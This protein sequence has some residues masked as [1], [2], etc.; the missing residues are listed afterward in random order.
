VTTCLYIASPS[1]SGSTLLTMLL[2]AHPAI[3]TIGE[4][5]GGQEELSSYG[6]SCGLLLLQCPFWNNLITSLEERGFTYDLSDLRTMP[7]FRTTHLWLADAILRRYSSGRL[8][9]AVRDYLFAIWPPWRKQLK[10]LLAYNETF[11]ELVIEMTGGSVFLDSSKDV[12]RIQYLTKIP[13]LDVRIIHLI[14]DGR[15]V[16]NSAR[17]NVKQPAYAAAS[18]WRDAQTAIERVADQ[19]CDGR[20]LRVRYEDLCR[21]PNAQIQ[22]ILQFATLSEDRQVMT[23]EGNGLH[24]LGNRM[25][26]RGTQAIRLDESWRSELPSADLK[27][28]ERIARDALRRYGYATGSCR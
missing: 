6:C 27:V 1:Y 28:C 23:V 9:N 10:R 19:F 15:A 24:I 14:R 18:E 16:V 13:S 26:L 7:A 20:I 5:K 8:F 2:G 4:M 17:K 3:A 25:R 12:L 21:N 11:I 22:R